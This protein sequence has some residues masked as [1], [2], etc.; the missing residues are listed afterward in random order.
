MGKEAG[1]LSFVIVDSIYGKFIWTK[2][3]FCITSYL[4]Y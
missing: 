4:L 3:T 1:G 2:H